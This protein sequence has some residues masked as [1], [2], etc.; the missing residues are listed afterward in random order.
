MGLI[1]NQ[2][3]CGVKILYKLAADVLKCCLVVKN[4][5]CNNFCFIEVR[6]NTIG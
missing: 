6:S 4:R 1:S 3:M 5:F 2:D